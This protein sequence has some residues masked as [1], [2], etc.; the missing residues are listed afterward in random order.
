[1]I[2]DYKI[3]IGEAAQWVVDYLKE[4]PIILDGIRETILFFYTGFESFFLLFP[5]W[6]LIILLAGLAYWSGKKYGLAL[7]TFL[8]LMLVW[9][10]GYWD[11]MV[12]TLSLVLTSAISSIVL[13]VPLGIWAAKS[14]TVYRIV[15]PVLD[16][17]QTMP[18]FVY[19]I[20]AILFFG[21]GTVPGV[22]ASVI[23]AVPPTIRLANLG[24]CLTKGYSSRSSTNFWRRK[25]IYNDRETYVDGY[26]LA[27]GALPVG[28]DHCLPPFLDPL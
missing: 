8:G 18:A 13:G 12:Y 7:F 10:L 21:I 1:M 22:I 16:F 2:E 28:F 6:L 5:P 25:E 3:P 15:T 11:H 23:F 9:N 17:M 24:S 20:P 4:F 14:K 26:H 27:C 19:L